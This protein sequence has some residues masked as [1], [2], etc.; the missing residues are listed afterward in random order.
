MKFGKNFVFYKIPEYSEYYFDYFSVKLFLRFLDNR[1]KKKKR[2]KKL[3]KLKHKISA[4]DI[5]PKSMMQTELMDLNKDENDTL[6]KK[7]TMMRKSISNYEININKIYENENENESFKNRET[8][9]EMSQSNCDKSL[10]NYDK[11]NEVIKKIEEISDLLDTSKLEHFIQF[12]CEKVKIVNDFFINKLNEYENKFLNIK[13][14]IYKI[15]TENISHKNKEE[16]N[17]KD[18]FDYATSWKRALSNLYTYTSW[19]H[20]YHNIN[21]LAIQKIQKKS[22]KIFKNQ[23]INGL[24]KAFEKEDQNFL[25]FQFLKNLI[26]LRI[27]IK[28]FYAEEFTNNDLKLARK[29]LQKFL[30]GH[31]KVKPI[32]YLYLGIIISFIL[33]YIFLCF[34]DKFKNNSV[35]TFFPAFNFSLLIILAFFGASLN[36]YI[37]KKYKIN[38]LYIFEVEPKKKIGSTNILEFSLLLL[39]FWCFFMLCAKIVYNYKIFGNEYYLFPLLIII[40]LFLILLIPLNIIYYDFRKGIII[41]FIKNLFPF[42][43]KGVRF[44]DFL[45]GDI[46]TS[47]SKPFCSLVFTFCL[48]GNKECREK[49]IRVSNCNRNTIGCFIILLYPNFIRLTQCINRLYYTKSLWPHFFN[50]L[51]YTGGIINIIFT[52]LYA[53]ND[54]TIFL[55]LYIIIAIIVN[56]Y[57]S[58]WDIYVD[59]GLGRIHSSN[60]FLRDTIVYPKEFYYIAIVLDVLI[61]YSWTLDFIHLNKKK[62]DEWKNLL[63][64]VIELYRRV[65]WC[66][67][68]IE[69]ENTTNPEKYREILTI[70]EIPEF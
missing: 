38:Y 18:E 25:F 7:K 53:K 63:F 12:Y 11:E 24:D 4:N 66:I 69:N 20:S 8:D 64:A 32:S 61:R 51:K 17:N 58:F 54:K 15:K 60:F 40:I 68:R 3:Q 6:K 43:K 21:L 34:N 23:N 52:W 49:N 65:Q 26:D 28:K 13:E 42:G 5:N 9:K 1:R 50:L 10:I 59:W 47:L 29:E 35:K 41:T 22:K 55:I 31:S 45:F 36:L 39:T 48:I 27:N 57:Q 67:I 16:N 70:P 37:L 62:Y 2:K 44:R 33:F 46:L 14:K 19:L 30:L 56:L